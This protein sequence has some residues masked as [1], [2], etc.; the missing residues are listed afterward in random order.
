[1]RRPLLLGSALLL[2]ATAAAAQ[3]QSRPHMEGC[4]V[5]NSSG[6]IGARNECSRPITI[7][8]MAF[9]DQRVI[10]AEVAGGGSFDTAARWG[11]SGGFMFTAC[12]AGH[13]P[14]VRFSLENK[15]AIVESLYNC[16][17]RPQA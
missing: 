13:A 15:T 6:R 17:G 3:D 11:E 8:F 4:L 1:M 10:E 16:L 7:L 14:S 5:W 2:A 12:P 9:A